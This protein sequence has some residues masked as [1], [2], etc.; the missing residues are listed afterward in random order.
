MRTVQNFED[1]RRAQAVRRKNQPISQL[2]ADLNALKDAKSICRIWQRHVKLRGNWKSRPGIRARWWTSR[3][4]AYW[5]T[6]NT[7]LRLIHVFMC[8]ATSKRVYRNKQINAPAYFRQTSENLGALALE[9]YQVFKLTSF[10]ICFGF[11]TSS[12][13]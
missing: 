9:R 6:S 7:S 4:K 8:G 3:Q 1:G 2:K 11:M 5:I 13:S 10:V 12:Y